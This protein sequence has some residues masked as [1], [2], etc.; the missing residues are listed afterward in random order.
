MSCYN[1]EFIGDYY[2]L[3]T[4]VSADSEE[5]AEANALVS[6]LREYGWDLEATYSQIEITEDEECEG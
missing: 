1:V 4:Q 3:I 5:E 2:N 6:I